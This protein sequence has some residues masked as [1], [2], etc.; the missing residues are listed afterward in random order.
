MSVGS[1][2]GDVIQAGRH[3]GTHREGQLRSPA[4][5]RRCLGVELAD[6]DGGLRPVERTEA[7]LRIFKEVG[8]KK[9]VLIAN[10]NL[11]EALRIEERAVVVRVVSSISLGSQ[12]LERRHDTAPRVARGGSPAL[13]ARVTAGSGAFP[14]RE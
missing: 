8:D 6:Q 5:Y 4:R 11:G 3:G 9:G 7:A 1:D 14:A 12:L 2:D 13:G 10:C